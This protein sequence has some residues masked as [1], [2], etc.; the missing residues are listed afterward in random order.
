MDGILAQEISRH[1]ENS[2]SF[3]ALILSK[4]RPKSHLLEF[5]KC[6]ENILSNLNGL[7]LLKQ[8]TH[9]QISAYLPF[10]PM[11]DKFEPSE[12]FISEVI[13]DIMRNFYP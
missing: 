5:E 8:K 4:W 11:N 2:V 7:F 6:K 13:E 1:A 9:F 3:P 12:D 10:D